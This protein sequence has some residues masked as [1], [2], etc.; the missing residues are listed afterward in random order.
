[1]KSYSYLDENVKLLRNIV[2]IHYYNLK[3]QAAV[4]KS[5]SSTS[6]MP[7]LLG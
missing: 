5:Y 3:V 1:M 7:K 6:K 2:D 4:H